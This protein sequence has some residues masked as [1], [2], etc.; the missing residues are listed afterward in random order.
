M[1]DELGHLLEDVRSIAKDSDDKRI[2]FIRSEHWIGYG[3]AA[4]ATYELETL[5]K[6]PKRLRMPNMLLI[7]PT[8]NGKSKLIQRFWKWNRPTKYKVTLHELPGD[9][10]FYRVLPVMHLQMPPNPDV[11]RFYTMI[12]DYLGFEPKRS[13]RTATLEVAVLN[14]LAEVHIEMLVIDEIHNI[15]AGRD[16]QQ[17][18]F[19]N[20]LRFLGN[21]LKIPIVGVGTR[22]AYLAIR[23]DSQLENRFQPFILPLWEENDEYYS[24]LASY[25][26]LFPL[27]N[28]SLITEPEEAHFI[29]QK[30]EGI[31]GEISTLLSRSAELAIISGHEKIDISVLKN[32]KYHSPTE[33]RKMMEQKLGF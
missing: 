26:A 10:G 24:L 31:L 16:H 12:M 32:T 9:Y 4:K 8:N 19:L 1:D 14:R 7:G 18:E 22:D 3:L 2:K 23:S 13:L 29:L 5:L 20:V 17:R 28:P 25:A 30:T 21:E 6:H 27:R 33:R 11:K 15:L